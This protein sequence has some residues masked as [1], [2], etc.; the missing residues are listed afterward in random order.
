MKTNIPLLLA[1]LLTGS[2]ALYATPENILTNPGFES[3]NF[4]GWTVGGTSPNSGVSVD[5]VALPG[6]AFGQGFSN[7]RSGNYAAFAQVKG[8]PTTLLILSQTLDVLPG[9]DVDV[10]FFVSHGQ[11]LALGLGVGTAKTQI[12]VDGT[13]LSLSP[14]NIDIPGGQAP[15]NFLQISASFNTGARDHLTLAFELDGSGNG[16]AINSF[17]DFYALTEPAQ[18][19]Q[20]PDGGK[21]GILVL[22]ATGLLI[23]C[24]KSAILRR[25]S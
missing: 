16:F 1:G 22:G 21:T 17:D 7:V 6:D 10:G 9:Q 5:G 24:R 3:G 4:D 12:L 14:S 15:A 8:T 13:P 2:A 19:T 18:T 23:Y 11:G 20:T 25:A